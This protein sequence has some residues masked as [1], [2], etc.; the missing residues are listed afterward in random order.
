MNGPFGNRFPYTNFHEMNL[1]WMIQIAKDFLDQYTNI[2]N[3][4][5]QGL[6]DLGDKTDTGLADLQTKYETLEGLLDAWYTE[7]SEDIAG[8]L[9]DALEDLNDW[10]TTHSHD[11]SD[12][13][14]TA[15][16]SFNTAAT[17]KSQELLDSWPDDYSELVSD[18]KSVV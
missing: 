10:Y 1:D 13:L 15:I 4:I 8:E 3:I 17:Q 14:A 18:R 16:S 12:E 5:E 11:I 2:Q 9:A 7:H 6:T